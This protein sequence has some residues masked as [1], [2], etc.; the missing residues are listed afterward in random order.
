MNIN[1]MSDETLNKRLGL[2]WVKKRQAEKELQELLSEWKQRHGKGVGT[3][4]EAG[5]VSVKLTAN[6]RFDAAYAAQYLADKLPP[7]VLESITKTVIDSKQAKEILP[8]KLY[9]E[10]GRD[11]EPKVRV[12]IP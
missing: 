7:E 10:C 1:Q 2:A 9:R 11:F 3:Q 6:R 8:P 12:D 5:G 4:C